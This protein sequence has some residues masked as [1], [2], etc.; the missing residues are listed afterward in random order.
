MKGLSRGIVMHSRSTEDLNSILQ[1]VQIP[2]F[3][4]AD[5]KIIIQHQSNIKQ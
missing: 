5:F 3:S 1:V 4:K 2:E